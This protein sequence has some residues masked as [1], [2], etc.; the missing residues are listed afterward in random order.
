[1]RTCYYG[2]E[3]ILYTRVE[4]PDKSALTYL[5]YDIRSNL[6]YPERPYLTNLVSYARLKVGGSH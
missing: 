1:M 3:L 2:Y 6:R 4:E 5:K